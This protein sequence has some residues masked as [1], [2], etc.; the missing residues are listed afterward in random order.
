MG[1]CFLNVVATCAK[2]ATRGD[3]WLDR[4]TPNAR[5]LFAVEKVLVVDF[6]VH[7]GN[8]TQALCWDDP[9]IVYFSVHRGF[10]SRSKS[11]TALFYPGTGKPSEVGGAKGSNVNVRWSEPGMGNAEYAECWR[12]IL[13]PVARDLAPQLILVSAGF[14]AARG[15][16]LGEC[17]LMPAGYFRLLAPLADL[18]PVVLCLEGGYNLDA[19]A[20]S[21]C[22]CAACLLGDDLFRDADDLVARRDALVDDRPEPP[23][24]PS[25]RSDI[26]ET[27]L[28]HARFWPSLRA[29][30]LADDPPLAALASD[31]TDI[32]LSAR[33]SAPPPKP[34]LPK[35]KYVASS[36]D[37]LDRGHD[38]D[39]DDD[40][41]RERRASEERF[42]TALLASL[43]A[44]HV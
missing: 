41:A 33:L 29:S 23:C 18:A 2:L 38:D 16:P 9:N 24:A 37:R 19:I 44:D 30:L 31:L 36:S 11:P 25:A 5:R 10:E 28:A 12:R 40:D 14:D 22:A 4:G 6:D 34:A 21:F 43:A 26:D 7:H 1:F 35:R 42:A 15:D 13:L 27:I 8:G 20:R 39:D 32:V 3:L 17:D